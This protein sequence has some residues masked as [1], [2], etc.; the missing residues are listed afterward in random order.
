M[1]KRELFKAKGFGINAYVK[2]FNLNQT[3]LSLVLDG[4]LKGSRVSSKGMTRKIIMRLRE[5]GVWNEPL[6]WK[7]TA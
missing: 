6:P 3:T 5:D 4:T 2:A 1:T 7:E